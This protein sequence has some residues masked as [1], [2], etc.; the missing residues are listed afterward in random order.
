MGMATTQCKILHQKKKMHTFA[1]SSFETRSAHTFITVL[2][3]VTCG[4]ILARI[5]IAVTFC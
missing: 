4:T 3:L 2:D 5:W 1:I